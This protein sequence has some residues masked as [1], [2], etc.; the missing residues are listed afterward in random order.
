MAEPTRGAYAAAGR[1]T[2]VLSPF[3]HYCEADRLIRERPVMEV[4]VEMAKVHAV[5]A[6]IPVEVY[7]QARDTQRENRPS[8]KPD[9]R[10][11]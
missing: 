1:A 5:L 3:E 9:E 11:S 7:V 2:V 10:A 4:N 6:A 8:A